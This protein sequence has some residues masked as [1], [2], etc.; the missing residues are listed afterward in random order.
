MVKKALPWLEV[1]LT[2]CKHRPRSLHTA[3]ETLLITARGLL[4]ERC[5]LAK[6]ELR[7]PGGPQGVVTHTVR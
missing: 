4:D 2:V 1:P 6:L 5:F 7:G 3:M